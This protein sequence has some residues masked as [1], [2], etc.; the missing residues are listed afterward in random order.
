MATSP[1]ALN[2]R[3][4][5]SSSNQQQPAHIRAESKGTAQ[6]PRGPLDHTSWYPARPGPLFSGIRPGSTGY[7]RAQSSDRGAH[8]GLRRPARITLALKPVWKKRAAR[9]GAGI[10]RAP[11][12]LAAVQPVVRADGAA[13]CPTSGEAWIVALLADPHWETIVPC[14]EGSAGREWLP[15][16]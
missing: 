12:A 11:L 3:L 4:Y 14:C 16:S 2:Q 9:V 1:N 7:H 6:T 5:Q 13:A 10:G 8:V 15:S